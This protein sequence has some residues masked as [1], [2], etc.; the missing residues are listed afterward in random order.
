MEN[1]LNLAWFFYLVS[2]FF[3][4]L[5][6]GATE[7][8]SLF[9]VLVLISIS[10]LF[11]QFYA[12][13][14]KDRIYKVP[15]TIF[16]AAG[17][18]Y[19]I[20]QIIP[21]PFFAVEI[22]SPK[23][24]EIRNNIYDSAF[25]GFYSISL[26]INGGLK[27]L[28]LI[29]LFYLVYY[30]TIQLMADYKILKKTLFY[31]AFFAGILAVSTILQSI[32]T[33]DMALWI[34]YVPLNSMVFGPYVNHNHYAG[35]MEMLLPLVFVL[36]LVYRPSFIDKSLREKILG[37]FQRE[38]AYIYIVF[39]FFAVVVILSVFMS[40]SRSGI[41]SM[42]VSLA[43]LFIFLRSARKNNSTGYS[44][45][46][47][48]IFAAAAIW[49]YGWGNIDKRFGQT[50][51]QIENG[52]LSRL[53]FWM[54]TIEIIKNFWLTGTGAGSFEQIY[55]YYKSYISE[56][57]IGHAHNDYLELIS[58]FGLIGLF[59]CAGFF[60]LIISKSFKNLKKRKEK[61]AVI[62]T[63]AAFSSICA[64]GVHSITDF[65]LQIPANAMIFFLVC[66]LMISFS[67]T[68]FRQNLEPS[69]LQKD[70]ANA[71]LNHLIVFVL[72]FFPLGYYSCKTMLARINS[73]DF[74]VEKV[75]PLSNWE[76][77]EKYT[78]AAQ[79]AAFYNPFD[80]EFAAAAGDSFFFK[81]DLKKSLSM[82][83]KSLELRPVSGE[84]LQKYGIALYYFGEEHR[85][86]KYLRLGSSFNKKDYSLYLRLAAFYF[87]FGQTQKGIETVKTGISVD[88]LKTGDL[89]ALMWSANLN[90][91]QMEKALP[92]ISEAYYRYSSF[93]S[94]L[95]YKGVAD[96]N[97]KILEKALFFAENEKKPSTGIYSRLAV[98]YLRTKNPDKAFEVISA[99]L[100]KYPE[101]SIILYYAG[102]VYENL[103]LYNKAEQYY[104]QAVT[105][106][107]DMK[108]A[109]K[110]LETLRNKKDFY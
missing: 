47:F 25:N 30:M 62:G 110:R 51:V 2:I 58:D 72:I 45:L 99:G 13:K 103:S 94:A 38:S 74:P 7:E 24:F 56:R 86:E 59:I 101:D 27:T 19:I 98:F 21:L 48:T 11:F 28:T 41:F 104:T 93:I 77:I 67:H 57:I 12:L 105:I 61:F 83:E 37:F 14:N 10:F 33:N 35:L 32:L 75:T 46:F 5:A 50:L 81:K 82:Y 16:F 89:L 6:F 44:I 9:T 106:D 95:D 76:D 97:S 42:C 79:K 102:L 3:A 17:F 52:Q 91:T 109:R 23:A 63:F 69:Y 87:D 100:K 90:F 55:P 31:L 34:R 66:A 20:L 18:F 53:N 85:G 40:L 22:L 1:K 107:P 84:I 15:G 8:W 26:N 88:P 60:I 43:V 96:Y 108:S 65:N 68:R 29:V 78:K 36:Y 71:C 80:A 92:P 4:P 70:K 73:F 49:W 64:I 39:G 54:D